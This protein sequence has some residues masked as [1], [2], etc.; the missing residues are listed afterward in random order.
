MHVYSPEFMEICG[1]AIES[2]EKNPCS[3]GTGRCP[4]WA[5]KW[6]LQHIYLVVGGLSTSHL[7]AVD[8]Q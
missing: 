8:S 3:G 1:R 4:L 2:A 5:V 6:T 7:Y